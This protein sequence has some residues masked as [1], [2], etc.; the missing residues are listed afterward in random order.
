MRPQID[1][2]NQI[3]EVITN[4][5]EFF[6]ADRDNYRI[7]NY[8]VNFES[9][10]LSGCE[11]TDNLL[12]ECRGIIFNIHGE[13]IRRPYH[14]F[15]NVG[16]VP[17]TKLEAL[18]LSQDHEY[19]E[20][21]DG[22]MIA[23]FIL[24]NQI[25]WATKMA[26]PAFHAM[27]VEHVSKKQNILYEQAVNN[28][29]KHRITLIFEWCSRQSRIVLD[30]PKDTLILTGARFMQSGYYLSREELQDISTQ[31]NIPLVKALN[32]EMSKED[33]INYV[34]S[35]KN[36]EGYVIRF[37]DNHGEM[38]KIKADDYVLAHKMIDTL[39]SEKNII[40]YICDSKI[41]DFLPM[42][43]EHRATTL[44]NYHKDV[45]TNLSSIVK[46]MWSGYNEACVNSETRKDFALKVKDKKYAS[47]MFKCKDNLEAPNLESLLRYIKSICNSNKYCDNAR[48]LWGN[49]KWK[50]YYGL[51]T[52]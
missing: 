10:F 47:Y 19:L 21:L 32:H 37:S 20:K 17:S 29:D 23:P 15:F 13:V 9:T 36:E 33:F 51:E 35:L 6:V 45:I 27:V 48:Y 46:Q 11:K 14:K 18:D 5:E 52:E 38:T 24:N 12:R 8:K 39:N 26:A 44:S 3:L 49:L 28:F 42:L 30:Y 1:N 22:S 25:I 34:R 40:Q 50:D 4:R 43:D 41:D 2:I 16:E 7:I 31:Y